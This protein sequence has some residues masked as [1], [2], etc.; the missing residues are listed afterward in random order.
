LAD[1]IAKHDLL[2]MMV[3]MTLFPLVGIS[4]VALKFGIFP[5]ISL[6]LLLGIGLIGFAKVK[7]KHRA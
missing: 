1:F 6:G 2:R 7:R 4:W 3:R 5:A